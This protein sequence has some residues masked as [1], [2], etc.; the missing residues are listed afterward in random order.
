M[1]TII[2]G[3]RTIKDPKIL[4]KVI[5]VQKMSGLGNITEVVCGCAAGVDYLGK[6]W[7]QDNNIPVK[8]FPADWNKHGKRA[9]FV[10]NIAMAKYADALLAIWD[11][12][13][14]GTH[15][16]IRTAQAQGL[17]VHGFKLEK[18]GKL[19]YITD[20]SLDLEQLTLI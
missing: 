17:E 4:E 18:D 6:F 10:R 20:A 2:A 1:K 12:E 13:S 3:S 11:G 7:A 15:H 5:Q 14:K 19:S 9:G 8:Y 16:M